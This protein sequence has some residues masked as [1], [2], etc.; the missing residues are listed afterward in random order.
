M[1][2]LVRHAR[3]D[4]VGS[5]LVGRT[6]GVSLGSAG[7][8]EAERLAA[9][10]AGLAVAIV[11]TS[12][13]ERAVET[14]APIA[15]RLGLRAEPAPGLDEIDFGAWAGRR[16]DELDGDPAWQAWNAE[17][18]TAPTPGGE[19]MADAQ[20]RVVRH[21][22]ALRHRLGERAAILVSH[23]DVIKAAV[24]HYLGLS[25]GALHRFEVAPASVTTIRVEDWGG[26]LLG[27]NAAA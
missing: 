6:A 27:L 24:A 18:A 4:L 26:T 2:Y 12:P 22:E 7:R 5:T 16:F 17:R 21:I 19:T 9:R 1:L 10:F 15:D 13:R 3:H 14:A 20:D 25:L 11:Q 23:A 8:A